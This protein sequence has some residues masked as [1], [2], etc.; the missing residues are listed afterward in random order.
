M[1]RAYDGDRAAFEVERDTKRKGWKL[2]RASVG[3]YETG[4]FATK[5][6]AMRW[7]EKLNPRIEWRDEAQSGR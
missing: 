7:A 2:W 5:D 6:E 1:T 3:C 4:N